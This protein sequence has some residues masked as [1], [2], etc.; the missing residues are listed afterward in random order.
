MELPLKK[1]QTLIGSLI[2]SMISYSF[3]IFY[4]IRI[5]Y[6]DQ[7]RKKCRIYNLQF[8]IKLIAFVLILYILHFTFYI[9]PAHAVVDPLSTT[10]NRFGIHIISATPNELIEAA[11]LVN[12]KGDWG[13]VTFLIESKDR[14]VNRWQEVFNQLRRHHLIPIVRIATKPTSDGF[15]ERP[16]EH[17]EVA[18][19]NFLDSLNWPTKNRYITIYNEPNHA[20]EWGNSVD[21]KSYAKVLDK[22]ITALKLKNQDFFVLNGGFDASTPQQPPNYYD[23]ARFIKEMDQE[24]PGIFNKLDGWVSHSYPNPGFV[25]SPD[26]FGRG[27]VRTYLW[28]L[29]LLK[30]LGVTKELPVFITET[31]WRHS[32]GL[33]KNNYLPSPEVV[34][35]YYKYA[36]ESTWN[37]SRIVAVTPFLLNYQQ[38]PFDHFSFKKVE[39]QVLG[40]QFP[41]YHP[42]Y[43]T[44]KE[45]PK[46][47]GKPL[48]ENSARFISGQAYTSISVDQ[49]HTIRLTVENTGQSIWDDKS[50]VMLVP[51]NQSQAMS[52]EPIYVPADLKIEPGQSHTFN[53]RLK[54]SLAGVYETT[55]NLVS[56]NASITPEP[57]K[58]QTEVKTNFW[59]TLKQVFNHPFWGVDNI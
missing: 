5:K 44:L 20:L 26:D 47:S 27:T 59:L 11:D 7:E 41:S 54:S 4:N 50:S 52:L 49:P 34:A 31:G 45:Y 57:F 35:G 30:T 23:E 8:T 33:Q 58:L 14:D 32:D 36:F 51:S 24:V 42:H 3:S 46:L 29:Q 10:N 56:N 43:L 28:E 1:T 37:D 53:I 25:G 15:W 38:A 55:F 19:A 2:S 18:W 40:A 12:S 16:Y 17:E 48:Q 39:S 22:T 13:Y 21:P 6:K 9:S